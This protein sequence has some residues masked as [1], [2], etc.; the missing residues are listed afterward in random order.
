MNQPAR[1]HLR[2][3]SLEEPS[4]DEDLV[5]SAQFGDRQAFAQLFRRH[6]RYVG[7][8][9]FRVMRSSEEVDD[10]VQET[11]L[12]A[13]KGLTSLDEPHAFRRWLVTIAIR[14][15]QRRIGIKA[16]KRA[17]ASEWGNEYHERVPE[18]A[19]ARVDDLYEA[20]DQ[21][22]PNLRIPWILSRIEGHTLPDVAAECEISLATSKRRIALAEERIK[23]RLGDG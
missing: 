14:K 23:R 4:S 9:I 5:R 17:L 2:S 6:A 22:E 10:I 8:V 12:A 19:R 18:H 11:F 7:G 13:H 15:V 20:L 21:I 16:R 1:R 3:V